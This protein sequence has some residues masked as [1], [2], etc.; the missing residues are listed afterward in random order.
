M[1]VRWLPDVF[2]GTAYAG[3]VASLTPRPLT[4]DTWHDLGRAAAG[5]IP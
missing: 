5:M 1:A 2:T 3:V 4:E